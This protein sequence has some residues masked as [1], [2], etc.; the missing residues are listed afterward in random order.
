MKY[1]LFTN[2]KFATMDGSSQRAE[3]MLVGGDRIIEVG[4]VWEV[5]GH[6]LAPEAEKVDLQ[7]RRVIPGLIDTHVHF[8]AYAE[9][10][11]AVDLSECRSIPEI[12]DK[13]KNR[14]K[15]LSKDRWIRGMGFDHS[16]LE[17]KRLPRR[18]DLD[19]IKNPVFLTRVCFHA[20]CV[21]TEALRRAG[22]LVPEVRPEGVECDATGE[23]TGVILESGADRIAGALH[24][25]EGASDTHLD[26]LASCMKEFAS[27]GLTSFNTTSAVHL[28]ITETFGVYQDLRRMQK[29][30][31]RV[32]IHFNEL[33]G[34]QMRSFFGDEMIRFGGLKIF[35]DG[36]FCAQTGA[37][38]FD[39][40]NAPGHRGSLNYSDEELRAIFLRAQRQGVQIAVHTVGDRA[41]EQVLDTFE[42]VMNA[43]PRPFLRH[44]ILH[45]YIVRGR[46]RK[47]MA[48]LGLI[49]DIQPRFVADEIDI[50]E[51]G[52]P[53]EHLV[54]AYAWKSLARDGVLITGSSDCPA[55]LPNPWLGIESAVNRVRARERTPEGGWYPQQ[56]LTLDESMALYT[57]HAAISLG[58]GRSLGTLEV[59]KLADFVV[60][61]DDPWAM[62]PQDLGRVRVRST[63]RGGEEI[64]SMA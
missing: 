52:V 33:P 10:K 40:K 28:G 38:S 64:Y 14:A 29:Q 13:L 59:G 53:A 62:E 23:P 16:L 49:G 30:L 32:T 50:A 22:L 61:E 6:P 15:D 21:N 2:G 17:E 8:A 3:A 37:M 36:G 4:T 43:C 19:E 35:A 25:D 31:Q 51:Y 5:A 12:V 63:W 39:Y 20:H 34:Q 57:A 46:Q 42:A 56:K 44:R 45:C 55:A 27:Y 58:V 54:D 60:L 48:S 47:K 24:T 18:Q 11:Q 26:T 7:G 9:G 41:M 1:T